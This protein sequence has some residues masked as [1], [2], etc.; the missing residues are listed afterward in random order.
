MDDE[1]NLLDYWRVVVKRRKLIISL[2]L[3]C[4][5]IALINSLMQPKLYK[6][7]ANIMPVD[8]GGGGLSA[9]L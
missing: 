3:I 7:T 8:S 4:A 5:I 2:T 1:I 9:A 6:A